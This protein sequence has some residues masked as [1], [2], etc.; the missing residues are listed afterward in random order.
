[1]TNSGPG[2][3]EHGSAE[4]LALAERLSEWVDEELPADLAREVSSH[5]EDCANCIRFVDSLR[6]IKQLPQELPGP[7]AGP[8]RLRE[9]AE[10]VRRKLDEDRN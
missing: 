6:R 9:L 8:A 1:M 3:H 2:K 7:Q 5:M 10:D 4:C